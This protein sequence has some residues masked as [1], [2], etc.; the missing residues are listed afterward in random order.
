MILDT[1]DSAAR[2]LPLNPGFAAAFEF[3][4]RADLAD[5]APGRHEI[6]GERVFAL[7][8]KAP[9]RTRDQGRL[10]THERYV[11]IQYL[12]AGCD[13]MGWRAKAACSAP[14]DAYSAEKD[15]QFFTD[16]PSAWVEVGPGQFAVFFPE[17][18]HLPMISAGELHKVVV[19]VA[20]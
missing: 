13:E 1:L 5:L 10:E 2:Y 4:A 9:G 14:Q 15:V 7:V 17:D 6:D 18:A 8:A 12:V 16:A 11:D 19:K 20:V 3:L